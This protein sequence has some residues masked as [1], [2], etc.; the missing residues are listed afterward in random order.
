MKIKDAWV[1]AFSF[2][3]ESNM[4]EYLADDNDVVIKFKTKEEANKY[5]IEIAP[6]YFDYDTSPV[7]IMRVQ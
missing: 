1:I 5:I 4:P 3:G 2:A 7:K 6:P